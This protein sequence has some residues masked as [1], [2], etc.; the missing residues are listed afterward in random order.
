MTLMSWEG[1]VIPFFSRRG[2]TASTTWA[3]VCVCV[4]V[5]VCVHVSVCVCVC[6]FLFSHTVHLFKESHLPVLAMVELSQALTV[7]LC[8]ALQATSAASLTVSLMSSRALRHSSQSSGREDATSP[9]CRPLSRSPRAMQLG[10]GGEGRG[11]EG[12]GGEGRGGEGR[13]GEGRGGEG[14]GGE[15]RGGEGRGGEERRGG[16]AGGGEGRGGEG[17]NE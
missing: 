4:C 6:L 8:S 13:G 12:R 5:C 14:R 9:T 7:T 10:R 11:G 2:R 17:M 1:L 15:G 3:P 16:E